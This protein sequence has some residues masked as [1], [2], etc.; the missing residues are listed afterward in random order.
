MAGAVVLGRASV[1][2]IEVEIGFGMGL[3]LGVMAETMSLWG[4]SDDA[5]V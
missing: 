5:S 4:S 3:L 1:L 2:R